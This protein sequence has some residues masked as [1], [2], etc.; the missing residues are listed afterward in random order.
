MCLAKIWL[1][2][3][4]DSPHHLLDRFWSSQ[5]GDFGFSSGGYQG[6]GVRG[7]RGGSNMVKNHV[8][9]SFV[10]PSVGPVLFSNDKKRHIP[11]SDEDETLHGL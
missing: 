11:S 6:R 2:V 10:G 4:L 8:C 1:L 9:S 7:D 5:D 3:F